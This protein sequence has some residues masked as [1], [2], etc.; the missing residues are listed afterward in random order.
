MTIRIT[1]TYT[2]PSEAGSTRLQSLV[3]L[4]TQQPQLAESNGHVAETLGQHNIHERRCK[5]ASV[6]GLHARNTVVLCPAH[7]RLLARNG[8]VN[9]VKL[10]GPIAKTW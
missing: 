6:V 9:E 1:C 5:S 3:G 10:P 4:L 8:L 2:H 7:V